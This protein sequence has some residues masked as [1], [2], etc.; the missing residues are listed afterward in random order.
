[1]I[2]MRNKLSGGDMWVH[3]DRVEEYLAAGHTLADPPKMKNPIDKQSK[4][5]KGSKADKGSK[6]PADDGAKA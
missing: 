3:E 5:S 1:M 6:D 4:G 2:K